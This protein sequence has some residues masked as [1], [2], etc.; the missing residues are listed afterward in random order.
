[1]FPLGYLEMHL[2]GQ[3]IRGSYWPVVRVCIVP[4]QQTLA[5]ETHWPVATNCG[6][7]LYLT[8]N[9][10][11]TKTTTKR[12]AEALGAGGVEECKRFS[13]SSVPTTNTASPRVPLGASVFITSTATPSRRMLTEDVGSAGAIRS[14]ETIKR[15]ND[16]Q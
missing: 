16:L 15:M 6:F 12:M 8:S 7:K 13:T 1:M 9:K 5:G 11:K 2:I 14:A 3:W 4:V 10:H